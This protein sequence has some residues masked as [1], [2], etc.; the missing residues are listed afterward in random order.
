MAKKHP[1]EWI[2]RAERGILK[3]TVHRGITNRTRDHEQIRN[4]THSLKQHLKM[5][6]AGYLEL[7]LSPQWTQF[8]FHFILLLGSRH[9]VRRLRS[10]LTPPRE[11]QDDGSRSRGTPQRP[12]LSPASPREERGWNL[13]PPLA[14]FQVTSQRVEFLQPRK[15]AC[16][17][18]VH[19]YA[20]R[21]RRPQGL[22]Q[23]PNQPT[24]Q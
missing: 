2:S 6:E 1:E 3:S 21:H 4:G 8:F 22:S 23:P 19:M 5:N 9:R 12:G 17:V 24:N 13:P 10:S 7:G 18:K 11:T 20:W 16:L 15:Q 14:C